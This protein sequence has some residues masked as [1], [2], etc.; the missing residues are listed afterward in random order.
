MQMLETLI[1]HGRRLRRFLVAMTL[2]TACSSGE[3]IPAPDG[4]SPDAIDRC[5]NRCTSDQLCVEAAE[6]EYTCAQICFNQLHC[7]SGCCV[8]LDGSPYNVCRPSTVCFPPK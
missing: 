6:G 1:T 4:G 7:W 5:G 3:A 8:P 2:V